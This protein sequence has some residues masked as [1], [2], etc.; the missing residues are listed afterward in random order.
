[1]SS[2]IR[3]INDHR[4]DPARHFFLSPA[5]CTT[6]CL[7]NLNRLVEMAIYHSKKRSEFDWDEFYREAGHMV[8]EG[9]G[10]TYYA[11]RGTRR[12]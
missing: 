12:S 10:S 9:I 5:S 3:H 11:F 1:M 8:I 2:F 7:A 4:Y 6:G